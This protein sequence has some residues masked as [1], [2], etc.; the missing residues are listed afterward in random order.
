MLQRKMVRGV[1]LGDGVAMGLSMEASWDF[2]CGPGPPGEL[3][4]YPTGAGENAKY[5]HGNI[6]TYSSA[7]FIPTESVMA[8]G[9]DAGIRSV[10]T[11]KNSRRDNS[12]LRRRHQRRTDSRRNRK[13]NSAVG[14]ES[15][16]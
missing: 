2:P 10:F 5:R 3:V 9:N 15:K 1:R 4:L 14:A 7:R 13:I 16:A 8:F 12:R 6:A 11:F